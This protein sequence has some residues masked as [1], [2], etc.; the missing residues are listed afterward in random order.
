MTRKNNKVIY[1]SV[2]NNYDQIP[3]YKSIDPSFDYICFSND[4]PEGSWI[5]HWQIRAI[6]FKNKRQILLSRYT[7]ILPHIVLPEYDWSI[8]LDA[9]LSVISDSIYR[10]INICIERNQLWNGI[11]HPRFDCI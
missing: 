7:K 5:G 4:F 1:T 8:W 3:Q 11:K 10:D 2:T 6:P 9:N